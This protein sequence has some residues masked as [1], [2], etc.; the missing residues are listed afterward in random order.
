MSVPAGRNSSQRQLGRGQG[1]VL[2]VGADSACHANFSR[3]IGDLGFDL[4]TSSGGLQAIALLKD[5]QV[6]MASS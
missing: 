2:L 4:V 3:R 1:S 5:R 6:D